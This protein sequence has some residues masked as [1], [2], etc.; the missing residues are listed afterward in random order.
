MAA[1]RKIIRSQHKSGGNAPRVRCV[2][3]PLDLPS[4]RLNFWEYIVRASSVYDYHSM[5]APRPLDLA[6]AIRV[7]QLC[8]GCQRAILQSYNFVWGLSLRSK[9]LKLSRRHL[10]GDVPQYRILYRL[11]VTTVNQFPSFPLLSFYNFG[12]W[13][14]VSIRS[15]CFWLPVLYVPFTTQEKFMGGHL[16]S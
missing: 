8:W 7:L 15:G 6:D 10:I 2:S 5:R 3:L 14:Q 4:K 12:F 1:M 16:S 9:D 11:I 13:H